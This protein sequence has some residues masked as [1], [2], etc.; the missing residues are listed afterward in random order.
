MMDDLAR[1]CRLFGVLRWGELAERVA[2]VQ[3][4]ATGGIPISERSRTARATASPIGSASE[5]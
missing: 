2:E 3:T 5:Q 4:K 1:A